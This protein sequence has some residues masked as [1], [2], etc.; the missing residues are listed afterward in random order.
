MPRQVT[1]R[2][3]IN[4]ALAQ[5]V[6]M[7]A[8]ERGVEAAAIEAQSLVKIMLTQPGTG[9]IYQRGKTVEHRA[10]SPGEPPAPDTGELR[11]RIEVEVLRGSSDVIGRITANTEYA[12]ALELGTEK[13]KPRP[14]LSRIPREFGA[15]LR[16]AFQRVAG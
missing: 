1:T 11:R 12:A 6:A 8:A 2:V 10:S 16:A 4:M 13:I 15:R 5:R 14:Y 7:D 3:E 9:R